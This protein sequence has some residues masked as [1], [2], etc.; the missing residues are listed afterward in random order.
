MAATIT[1]KEELRFDI[2]CLK[3]MIISLEEKLNNAIEQAEQAHGYDL[4][5]HTNLFAIQAQIDEKK[6]ELRLKEAKLTEKHREIGRQTSARDFLLAKELQD[7]LNRQ[8]LAYPT[9]TQAQITQANIHL[10]AA[11]YIFQKDEDIHKYS[12]PGQTLRKCYD[13]FA[14]LDTANN[15]S[16]TQ[17][18]NITK[19][20]DEILAHANERKTEIKIIL[21]SIKS[22]G[23]KLDPET[24][25]CAQKILIK[26]WQLAKKLGSSQM[27]AVCDNLAHNMVAKG[28]CIPGIIT[29]LIQPYTAFV[30]E[31]LKSD[32]NRHSSISYH[33]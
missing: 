4:K 8:Q 6:A 1:G 15:L 26:T 16:N 31:S 21:N 23:N 33:P 11:K 17:I 28:G 2:E 30:N 25:L 20:A 29:R 14:A 12:K 19:I 7:E 32:S 18:D 22:Q 9:L 3:V 27:H 24:G 10:D 5:L 13:F